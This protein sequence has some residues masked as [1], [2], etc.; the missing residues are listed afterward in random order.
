MTAAGLGLAVAQEDPAQNR[1]TTDT[2]SGQPVTHAGEHDADV[3]AIRAVVDAFARGYNAKDAQAL[4]ALFTEEAEIEDEAGEVTRGRAAIVARFAR[5]FA[6][7]QGGRLSISAETLHF[8]GP[9]LAIE[10]GTATIT[11][12][13]DATPETSRYSVIYARQEGRWLHARIRDESPSEVA[14]HERLGE[15]GWMLGDWINE[16]DDAIVFTTCKWSDDG[17]FLIRDFDIKVEGQVALSGT[18]RIGWDPLQ[19]QFRT[20]VFD[21]EGGF[22]EG[23]MSRGEDR[24]EVQVNGVR[25][26]GQPVSAT[27]IITVLGKDRIGWQTS[28]R[29]V[30]GV[31]MPDID[32]FV[33]VR[34]PPPPGR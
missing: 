30:G 8:P 28:N 11:P 4:G 25:P 17:N 29:T 14:P 3:K 21:T 12:G 33:L 26:D 6:E 5:L 34:R 1:R 22:A 23:L 19:K 10:E 15:L 20:W 27:N 13:G 31:A 16:S 9:G 7:D 2:E 32:R 18:Q 24:W